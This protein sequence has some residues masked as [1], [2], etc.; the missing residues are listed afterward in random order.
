MTEQKKWF[1]WLTGSLEQKKQYKQQR[2]R[3]KRLP[4]SYRQ[5]QEGIERY[6]MYRGAIQ[7]GV[8]LLKMLED[9]TQL[10]EQASADGTPVGDVVG[11]DPVEFAEEFLANY[12][13]SQWI[14][15][16][17]SRLRETLDEASRYQQGGGAP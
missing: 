13:D 17:K 2:A 4:S 10:M 6:L 15:K 14:N 5:A 16:E 3:M 9:L 1:G 7:D 8:E 12:T 11:E